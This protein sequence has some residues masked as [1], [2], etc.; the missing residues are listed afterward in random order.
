MTGNSISSKRISKKIAQSINFLLVLCFLSWVGCSTS[1]KDES[2]KDISMRI[3]SL[4]D[5]GRAWVECDND[6]YLEQFHRGNI[7]IVTESTTSRT[8]AILL[9]KSV[10]NADQVN[11]WAMVE[12]LQ[13]RKS[14]SGL[15]CQILSPKGERHKP[16][17]KSIVIEKNQEGL[18][19]IKSVT[20]LPND[21]KISID[22]RV[23]YYSEKFNNKDF[24]LWF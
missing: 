10:Q 18:D 20:D 1:K 15:N 9:I 8:K 14:K 13:N 11:N 5:D 4:D 7:L 6:S 17:P 2:L 16:H 21:E 12:A 22:D 23:E 24:K 3:V 19:Y